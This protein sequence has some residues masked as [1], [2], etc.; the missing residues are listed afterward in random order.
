MRSIEKAAQPDQ[1]P[2]TTPVTWTSAPPRV[3]AALTLKA[4]FWDS[5]RPTALLN[6]RT[7]ASGELTTLRVGGT[8]LTLRCLEIRKDSVRLKVLDSGEEKLLHLGAQ[9]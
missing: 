8:N 4:I 3:Y 5:K 2:S 6:E 7:L 9:P 1:P